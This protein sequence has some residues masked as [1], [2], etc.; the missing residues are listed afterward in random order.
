MPNLTRTKTER[1]PRMPLRKTRSS[2]GG[3]MQVLATCQTS[4]RSPRIYQKISQRASLPL[5]TLVPSLAKKTHVTIAS[6]RTHVPASYPIASAQL[7]METVAQQCSALPLQQ[8]SST[9][10]TRAI[11]NVSRTIHLQWVKQHATHS[12]CVP[13]TRRQKPFK[14]TFP[15]A[16]ENIF[17]QFH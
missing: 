5:L 16:V 17:F 7:M 6:P 4:H 1:L 15:I 11:A 13:R 14:T 9:L 8:E 2:H 3:P 10:L 12:E